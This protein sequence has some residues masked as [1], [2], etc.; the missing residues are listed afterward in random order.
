MLVVIIVNPI[1]RLMFEILSFIEASY[2]DIKKSK[3]E[4]R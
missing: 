1:D 2:K 3:R 4:V